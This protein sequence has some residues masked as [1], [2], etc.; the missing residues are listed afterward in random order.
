MPQ[1][2]WKKRFNRYKSKTIFNLLQVFNCVEVIREP[3]HYLVRH[4]ACYFYIV[5][6]ADAIS[7]MKKEELAYYKKTLPPNSYIDVHLW[8]KGAKGPLII[9]F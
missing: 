4:R 5:V 9:P 3:F 8:K 7:E 1:P 2:A 6:V